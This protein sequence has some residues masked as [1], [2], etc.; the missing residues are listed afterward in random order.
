LSL[1]H[2]TATCI[3]I[4]DDADVL[5][6]AGA[7]DFT[8]SVVDTSADVAVEEVGV[9]VDDTS[10]SVDPYPSQPTS[11]SL[12][13]PDIEVATVTATLPRASLPPVPAASFII[14]LK[15]MYKLNAV[16]LADVRSVV[17]AA[18]REYA[19]EHGH[20]VLDE[21]IGVQKQGASVEKGKYWLDLTIIVVSREF[22]VIS[23][24]LII[25]SLP[26]IMRSVENLGYTAVHTYP[27]MLL[28]DPACAYVC[29]GCSLCP[30]E[31][32]C[33]WD[34]DCTSGK[35]EGHRCVSTQWEGQGVYWLYTIFMVLLIIIAICIF[36][37]NRKTEKKFGY[38]PQLPAPVPRFDD[39][40]HNMGFN[41]GPIGSPGHFS[42]S[43]S[44][45]SNG[46]KRD[47]RY[48]TSLNGL[49]VQDD[50]EMDHRLF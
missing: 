1:P 45:S 4:A 42:R 24:E 40:Y 50:Y 19:G 21:Q 8:V 36:C 37:C 14:T 11:V 44:S 10:D 30:D 28:T 5:L 27:T 3:Y 38:K 6:L 32:R 46:R 23:L 20:E 49:L 33:I 29:T 25:P 9:L 12:V 31:S 41:P 18:L 43:N 15:R 47:M 26:Y 48:T 39:N 22:H 2:V 35:C 7:R 13:S 17:S 34:D 16:S